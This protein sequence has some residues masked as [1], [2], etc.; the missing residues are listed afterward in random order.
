MQTAILCRTNAPLIRCLFDLMKRRVRVK[1]M[2]KD[3]AKKLK[4]VMGDV[5]GSRRYCSI[6]EFIIQLDAWVD[7]YRRKLGN[8]PSQENLLSEIEDYYGCLKAVAENNLHKE[9]TQDLFEVIDGFF[10]DESVD[11]EKTITLCSGHKSK[12]LEWDRVIVIRPDLLPHPAAKTDEQ[13]AQEENLKYVMFTRAKIEMHV[14]VNM[15]S[16]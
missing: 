10:I 1:M 16:R 12:G 2:G 6:E 9:T 7:Q 8:N 5:L 11:D 15:P 13:I 3:I 4:D 14:V